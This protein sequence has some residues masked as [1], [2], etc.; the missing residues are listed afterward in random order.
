MLFPLIRFILYI[1]AY[2]MPPV[3]FF[4]LYTK[5][6]YDFNIIRSIPSN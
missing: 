3:R 1:L 2:K 6:R 4:L 5:M